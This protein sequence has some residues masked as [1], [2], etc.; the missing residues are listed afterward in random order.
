[1]GSQVNFYYSLWVS[2]S[3]NSLY[4]GLCRCPGGG[5]GGSLFIEFYGWTVGPNKFVFSSVG[6]LVI[7][8]TSDEFI[9]VFWRPNL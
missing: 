1:M 5:G 2:F 4:I 7:Q 9:W 6:D 8:G 3:K